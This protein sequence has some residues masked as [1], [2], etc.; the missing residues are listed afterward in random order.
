MFVNPLGPHTCLSSFRGVWGKWSLTACSVK[1]GG[2]EQMESRFCRY[3]PCYTD[4]G[5]VQKIEE[6]STGTRCNTFACIQ[7]T[8]NTSDVDT[9]N[10][11]AVKSGKFTVPCTFP[12]TYKNKEY[13]TC[14]GMGIKLHD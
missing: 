12:F 13:D 6:R 5:K 3:P 7:P 4:T 8:T 9:V 1:C 14:I 11:N 10:A 2:G